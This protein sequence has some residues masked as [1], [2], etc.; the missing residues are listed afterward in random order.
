M[1]DLPSDDGPNLSM[2]ANCSVHIETGSRLHFGLLDTVDP[3]GGVGVM[4]EQPV[5]QVAVSPSDWFDCDH[6]DKARIRTIA[7]RIAQF[8]SLSELP[9]CSVEVKSRAPAHHGF[10][11]GTQLA[12][13]TAEAICRCLSIPCDPSSI[14]GQI[15]M[16]GQRSA[17]GVHGYFRGGL[18]FEREKEQT[19]VNSLLGRVSLPSHWCVGLFRPS[20]SVQLVSGEFEREQF[21]NLLPAS[22]EARLGLTK[23]VNQILKA[24]TEGC[25][26][27][28]ASA[29][30]RYNYQ[31]G[32]LFE[33]VQGGPYNGPVVTRVIHELIDRGAG[34]VGQSSWGP[35][36]FAWFES[37]EEA[38]ALACGLSPE[39]SLVAITRPRNHPRTV[40]E[41]PL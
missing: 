1:T 24:G 28:F 25:F 33:A 27:T 3:F 9:K 20:Q 30:H 6:Q 21:A 13:A 5:T 18:I 2:A 14:A 41:L 8:A 39:T 19:A 15:A 29:V 23:I 16:R 11:S 32:K 7:A 38:Q 35:G 31:S 37:Q 10:G 40:H 36:V 34:G 22:A 4:I 26:A 17:V 12:L